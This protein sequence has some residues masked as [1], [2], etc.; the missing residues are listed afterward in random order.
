[1][2]LFL[3]LAPILFTAGPADQPRIEILT[4]SA[5]PLLPSFYATSDPEPSFDAKR[6]LFSGMKTAADPWQIFELDLATRKTRQITNG[7]GGARFP[8]YQSRIFTLDAPTPW[9][10]VVFLRQGNLHTCALDGKDCHPITFHLTS[11]QAGPP[12]V[13]WDGRVI[14]PLTAGG[15]TRLFAVNLDGTDFALLSNESVDPARVTTS[16]DSLYFSLAGSLKS[17]S[18]LRPSLAA[19][20]LA[21]GAAHPESIPDG[22]ILAARGQTLVL[23]TPA[24]GAV[25]QVLKTA[26]PI[27]QPRLL[28]RR[29]LP[30]GRGSVVDSTDQSGVLYCLSAHTSDYPGAARARFVRVHIPGRAPSTNEL[31]PDGSFHLKLPANTPI[32]VETLDEARQPIRR[33][34][35]F[36]VR[37]RENRGCIGCHENPELTPDNRSIEALRHKAVDLTGTT[38]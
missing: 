21:A 11:E 14:Y 20:P 9:D 33:S 22:G 23:F 24:T 36:W 28:A 3:A 15:G 1:M 16:G 18:L 13:G 12:A 38:Q 5:R 19:K 34:A 7:E 8:A 10:Q 6:V 29:P 4:Q 26:Y 2:L 37:N 25:R 30:D 31:A 27:R 32:S 17:M 35:N